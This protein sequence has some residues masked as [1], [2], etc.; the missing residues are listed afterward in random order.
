MWK[1]LPPPTENSPEARRAGAHLRA[2][3]PQPALM[4]RLRRPGSNDVTVGAD[5]GASAFTGSSPSIMGR[6]GRFSTFFRFKG[7]SGWIKALPTPGSSIYKRPNGL[8][9]TPKYK[10]S[11]RPNTGEYK[12]LRDKNLGSLR[13]NRRPINTKRRSKAQDFNIQDFHAEHRVQS[14]SKGKHN[15]EAV[16]QIHDENGKTLKERSVGPVH[17]YAISGSA[18]PGGATGPVSILPRRRRRRASSAASALRRPH[19]GRRFH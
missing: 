5:G 8:R 2:R 14:G 4:P 13:A 15:L 12:V 11:E 7:Q 9:F 6:K 19:A 18:F 17:V 10:R 3:K 1:K 16:V